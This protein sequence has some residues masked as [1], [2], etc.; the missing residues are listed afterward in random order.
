[1]C[2]TSPSRRV[3]WQNLL[4]AC[5]LTCKVNEL[6]LCDE[7]INHDADENN[8]SYHW[9][10]FR[11]HGACLHHLSEP[12]LP[13]CKEDL[14]RPIEQIKALGPERLKETT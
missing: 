6:G 2:H 8:S 4:C 12:S 9:G 10:V 11:G 5:F 3:E 14:A 1:M 7:K 13:L